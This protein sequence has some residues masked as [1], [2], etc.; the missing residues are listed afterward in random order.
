MRVGHPLLLLLLG[1]A[2]LQAGASPHAA[3]QPS[4]PAPPPPPAQAAA[5]PDAP[6]A[7]AEVF[8]E[9]VRVALTQP[10]EEQGTMGALAYPDVA[11]VRAGAGQAR[12]RCCRALCS[13]GGAAIWGVLCAVG[14]S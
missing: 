1:R 5:S 9:L 14:W 13:L 11:E 12:G 3:L 4:W 2:A 8:H 10:Q 6:Q 7:P